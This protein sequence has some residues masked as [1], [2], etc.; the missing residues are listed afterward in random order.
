MA[1]PV[2]PSIMRTLVIAL[3]GAKRC[4]KDTAAHYIESVYGFEHRKVSGLLKHTL[5]ALFGFTADQMETDL[6]DHEDPRWGITPRSMMQFFGTEMM[7]FKL[8]E[9][10]PSVGR[11]FWIRRLV[12][13]IQRGS[14]SKVVISDVRFHHEAAAL[15]A[16]GFDVRIVR[17]SKPL[18]TA[19][20]RREDVHVSEQEYR[21]LAAD[22][23]LEN[24]GDF[25]HLYAQIDAAMRAMK[26]EKAPGA[27]SN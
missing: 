23:E 21:S 5:Q 10:L 14:C 17:I 16:A 26:L 25:E 3:C 1:R 6:K 8:Q 24:A 13:E 19:S 27:Q 11:N 22:V 15:R 12:E 9:A 7:Q 4:G 20:A 18:G 2:S